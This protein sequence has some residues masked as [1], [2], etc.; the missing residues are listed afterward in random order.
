MVAV[1]WSQYFAAMLE[2]FGLQLPAAISGQDGAFN[3][4]AVVVVLLLTGILVVGIKLSARF[5]AIVVAIKVAGVLF[6][7]AAGL[8]FVN[9]A[10]YSPFVPPSEPAE[11]TSG[12]NATLVEAVFGQA[13]TNFGVSGIFAGRERRRGID[14]DDQQRCADRVGHG[15]PEHDDQGGNRQEPTTDA[16][17]AGEEADHQVA[18]HDVRCGRARQRSGSDHGWALDADSPPGA[19]RGA[20]RGRGG[21]TDQDPVHVRWPVPRADRRGGSATQDPVHVGWPSLRVEDQR[22]GSERSP[23]RTT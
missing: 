5:N 17:E 8:F 6:V 23:R 16:E 2:T 14:C 18:V 21:C 7:I 13:P 19:R 12:G 10:N 22:E 3:L 4:P 15:Y 11:A 9:G 1:G 20:G